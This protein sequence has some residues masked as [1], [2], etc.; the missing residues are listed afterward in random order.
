MSYGELAGE[1][2][3][4]GLLLGDPE[5]EHDCFSDLTHLSHYYNVVGMRNI[6]F[7]SFTDL[8]DNTISGPSL[9]EYVK[10]T[11]PQGAELLEQAFTASL[12]HAKLIYNMAE[13]TGAS[14]P[15][16]YDMMLAP[17]NLAGRQLIQH[18]IA[19]LKDTTTHLVAVGAKLGF[20]LDP[21]GSDSLDNPDQVLKDAAQ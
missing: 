18:L 21:E 9:A 3:Q 19:A 5:E 4:L 20:M 12:N 16:T 2:M 11:H 17:D 15:M 1:R 14:S 6:Y 10:A 7:G 13:H 8:A